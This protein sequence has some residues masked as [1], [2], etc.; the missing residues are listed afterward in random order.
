MMS[1]GPVV[2]P[3]I[4]LLPSIHP[5]VTQPATEMM[6]KTLQKWKNQLARRELRDI[7]KCQ[8]KFQMVLPEGVPS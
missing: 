4:L 5:S 1:A 2:V 6:G 7:L 3:R 8:K